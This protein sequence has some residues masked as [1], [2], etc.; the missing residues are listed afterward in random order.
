ML[1]W[2]ER[3]ISEEDHQDFTD[4]AWILG[5]VGADFYLSFSRKTFKSS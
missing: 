3:F 1:K 2:L 5:V 4:S